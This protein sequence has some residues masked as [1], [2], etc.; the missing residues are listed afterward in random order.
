MKDFH[1]STLSK[2]PTS[3]QDLEF[4]ELSPNERRRI[5][6]ACYRFEIFSYLFAHLI[7]NHFEYAGIGSNVGCQAGILY[8]S[9]FERWEFE[10]LFC[11][12]DYIYRAYDKI[13][14][15]NEDEICNFFST[16]EE[17]DHPDGM[18]RAERDVLARKSRFYY[19]K[20][21]FIIRWRLLA[22]WDYI[23]LTEALMSQGLESLSRTMS[24][25]CSRDKVSFVEDQFR[26][27]LV[28][29]L[30][31][32][33]Q[34]TLLSRAL[35]G[36]KTAQIPISHK[37]AQQLANARFSGDSQENGPNAAWPWSIRFRE[38]VRKFLV[39]LW[40]K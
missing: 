26:R 29:Q 40:T 25:S 37:E 22:A 5:Y 2:H 32:D 4:E 27:Q 28:G 31:S 36:H 8:F 33:N 15:D 13:F 24:F 23:S 11:L 3:G 18:S 9:R 7:W 34:R 1:C 10:E 19:Q 30:G 17:R 16:E 6:R 38:D 20:S 21:L 39:N 12:R 35:R 14:K